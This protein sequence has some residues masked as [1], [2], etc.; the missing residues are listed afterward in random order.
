MIY[1]MKIRS[2]GGQL[3]KM[4]KYVNW[5]IKILFSKQNISNHGIPEEKI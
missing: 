3:Y 4:R 5:L 1:F 2:F